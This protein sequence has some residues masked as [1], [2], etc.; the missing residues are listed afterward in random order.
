MPKSATRSSEQRGGLSEGPILAAAGAPPRQCSANN[1]HEKGWERHARW[2]RRMRRR[3]GRVGVVTM[4]GEAQEQ[5]LGLVV[6][7]DDVRLQRPALPRPR[8]PQ[9]RVELAH[10]DEGFR[11]GLRRKLRK[12]ALRE[13]GLTPTCQQ[14][15]WRH[16]LGLQPLGEV[17]GLR[18]ADQPAAVFVRQGV[19]LQARGPRGA[20]QAAVAAPHQPPSWVGVALSCPP[21]GSARASHIG[22]NARGVLSDGAADDV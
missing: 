16:C 3:A 8:P 14:E 10:N 13:L 15:V 2:G 4:Y 17:C 1:L 7:Q 18:R 19:E 20:L 5:L 11:A 21:P 22:H 12:H 9:R 6:A